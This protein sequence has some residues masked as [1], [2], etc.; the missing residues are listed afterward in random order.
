MSAAA[1]A[2]LIAVEACAGARAMPGSAPRPPTRPSDPPAPLDPEIAA[3]PGAHGYWMPDPEYGGTLYVIEAGP[4]DPDAI[5]AGAGRAPALVLVHGLGGGVRDYYPV[6]PELA[7]RRRVIAFDLPGFSRSSRGNARYAPDRYAAVLYE[8]IASYGHGPVDVLGHSMGGA[9]ALLHAATYPGQVHRLVVVD[10]AGILHREAWFGQNLRRVTDPTGR[11]LPRIVDI[12]NEAADALLDKTR[13]L[14]PAP[15]LLLGLALLRQ[16]VLGGEPGR[17]AALSL[18]LYDFSAAL[19]RVEAP[20]LV[21]WGGDDNVAPLRTGQLLADRLRDA[22][23]VVIPGVDH[24]VMAGAPGPLVAAVEEHLQAPVPPPPPA[25]PPGPSQGTAV[26]HG[27]T[28]LTFTGVYDSVTLEDCA[29]VT[30]DHVRAARLTM[31]QSS[32][33]VVA[34]R[35]DRGVSADTSELIMTGG[36][37]QGEVAIE[38]RDSRLDLAGVA[39]TG[40]RDACQVSGQSQVLFSVSPVQSGRRAPVWRH[41]PG[42]CT[43]IAPAP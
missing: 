42:G 26:C 39:V 9:I 33:N 3:L 20:T 18:L 24:D 2:V 8:V 6:L 1:L 16:K 40:T 5:R 38:A 7:R 27:Q 17:I 19:S 22:R 10:A 37:I 30:L 32:A 35:F 4:T 11:V 28:D 14:D 23:L 41:G 12:V 15:E 21:V 34:S 29:H 25:V 13:L 36:R 31:R 43:A